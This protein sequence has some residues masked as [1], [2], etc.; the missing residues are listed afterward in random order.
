MF[1]SSVNVFTVGF[2][3]SCLQHDKLNFFEIEHF[4]VRF[5]DVQRIRKMKLKLGCVSSNQVSNK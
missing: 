1:F 3:K 4:F 5:Y 2:D